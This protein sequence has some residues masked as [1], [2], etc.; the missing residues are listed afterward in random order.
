MP[1]KGALPARARGM[2]ECSAP[3]TH[4][5]RR[6]VPAVR[7]RSV[8]LVLALWLTLPASASAQCAA[9][10]PGLRCIQTAAPMARACLELPNLCI[11]SGQCAGGG[12]R[13]IDSSE[14]S[15]VGITLLEPGGPIVP[16]TRL[17]PQA[18]RAVIAKEAARLVRARVSSSAPEP[19]VVFSTLL[20]GGGGATL[21][22]RAS[23]GDGF[24]I[25]RDRDR[26]RGVRLVVRQLEHGR[27]GRVLASEQAGDDDLLIVP[28][29]FGGRS[30]L[31]AL[32]AIRPRGGDRDALLA[33]HR[34]AMAEA[35]TEASGEPPFEAEVIDE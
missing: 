26:V 16:P 13:F 14:E 29:R 35:V 32:Q 3:R 21:A 11:L 24:S 18:G 31:V 17:L 22:L 10:G 34:A 6:E 4:R 33:P 15:V 20:H 27:P 1:R 28:V 30:R 25:R 7:I 23:G 8:G 2:H 12:G 9:C 5:P 19:E